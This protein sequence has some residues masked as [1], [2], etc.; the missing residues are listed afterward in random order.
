VDVPGQQSMV[1]MGGCA[2]FSRALG[3]S[4]ILVLQHPR[5]SAPPETGRAAEGPYGRVPPP[6]PRRFAKSRLQVR[7][8]LTPAR[9]GPFSGI[10]VLGWGMFLATGG[11]CS[12]CIPTVLATAPNLVGTIGRP[13]PRRHFWAW[14]Q[15]GVSHVGHTRDASM[16]YKP[17]HT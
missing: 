1:T 14:S 10:F 5:S 2:S 13:R 17:H 7:P 4:Q 12:T 3:V 16:I 11:R 6:L 9:P 8:F 15:L